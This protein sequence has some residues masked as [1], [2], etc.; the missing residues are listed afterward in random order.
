VAYN[1]ISYLGQA[2]SAG[3]GEAELANAAA[4]TACPAATI[5][6]REELRVDHPA[7]RDHL[8]DR[9]PAAAGYPIVNYEYAVVSIRQPTAAAASQCGPS[10]TGSSHGNNPSY[11]T[12]GLPA[13]PDDLKALGSTIARSAS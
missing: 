3:L 8:D 12:R 13:L 9:R 2:R 1:G 10:C 4:S 5:S 7:E 11:V 6:P